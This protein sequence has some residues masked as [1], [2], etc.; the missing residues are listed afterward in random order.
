MKIALVTANIGG[1]DEDIV[2]PEQD[3]PVDFYRFT[4][5]NLPVPL[6]NLNNRLKSKYVKTQLHRILPEYD[7]YVWIDGRIE[8]S[9]SMF[10][11]IM[12]DLLGNYNQVNVRHPEEISVYQELDRIV[13][14][15]NEGKKYICDRYQGQRIE[16]EA[17]FLEKE[18]FPRNGTLFMG[19]V[20]ARLNSP[21][22][23]SFHDE[24]WLK[25]IE[26]S[27]FDQ[28]MLSYMIWKHP[29][30]VNEVNY[31]DIFGNLIELKKHKQDDKN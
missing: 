12:I 14:W 25:C 19:G 31:K 21:I 26:F 11:S 10:I 7:A 13:A 27:S 1:I 6:P 29:I 20:F 23:N 30:K 3:I 22:V 18:R 24:W 16:E 2:I 28:A 8:V 17:L 5:K 4:E 9:S 15:I